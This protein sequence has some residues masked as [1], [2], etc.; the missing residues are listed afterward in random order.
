[1]KQYVEACT[2]LQKRVKIL[3]DRKKNMDKANTKYNDMLKKPE[4]KQVG[5]S[6]LKQNYL[7]SRDSWEYLRDEMSVDIRK[8]LTNMQTSFDGLC[9]SFMK[10][11]AKYMLNTQ[12]VW[13]EL[14]DYSKDLEKKDLEL[15]EIMTKTD[16]SM[17]SEQNVNE[18]RQKEIADG[19]YKA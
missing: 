10:N 5:L 11:Y 1:M 8:T 7:N 2:T 15:D 4:A 18:R 17:V 19:T 14:K 6:D 12:K 13:D 3:D 16:E 9:R